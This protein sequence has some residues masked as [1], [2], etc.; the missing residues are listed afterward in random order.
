[1]PHESWAA[2]DPSE[3]GTVI[4][5]QMTAHLSQRRGQDSR[6]VIP[7]RAGRVTVNLTQAGDFTF[8][9]PATNKFLLAAS[10]K[11]GSGFTDT[12]WVLDLQWSIRNDEYQNPVTMSPTIQLTS[13]VKGL[14][15]SNIANVPYI[16]WKVTTAV[17]GGD[18]SATIL[19]AVE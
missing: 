17:S 11:I 16:R 4:E 3:P 7:P 19:Y 10:V 13:S 12:T 2:F 9:V 15:N 6:V 14:R 18:T 8:W 5:R 1:M